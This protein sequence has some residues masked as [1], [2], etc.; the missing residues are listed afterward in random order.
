MNTGEL[1]AG[2]RTDFGEMG[3]DSLADYGRR[4]KD[5]FSKCTSGPKYPME[6]SDTAADMDSSLQAFA[7]A[8]KEGVR[9]DPTAMIAALMGSR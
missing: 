5:S 1:P 3:G 9:E 7:H 6:K 4:A 8:R 2:V